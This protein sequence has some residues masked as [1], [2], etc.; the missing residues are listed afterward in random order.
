M[1]AHLPLDCATYRAIRPPEDDD[2]WTLEAQLLAAAVDYLGSLTAISSAQF[3][4]KR[5]VNPP[6]QIPRPGV[7]AR[8]KVETIKGDSFDTIAEFDAWYAERFPK[9]E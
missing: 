9:P 8:R 2:V 6:D 7:T 1:A 3:A 5:R 4:G